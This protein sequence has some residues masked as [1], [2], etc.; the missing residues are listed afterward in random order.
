MRRVKTVV[1]SIHLRNLGVDL[2]VFPGSCR[3]GKGLLPLSWLLAE[4]SQAGR[5]LPTA[6]IPGC[7]PRFIDHVRKWLRMT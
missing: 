1:K 6:G 2:D 7:V 4:T 3:C 5:A